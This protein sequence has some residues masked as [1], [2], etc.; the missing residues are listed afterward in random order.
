M[1]DVSNVV[2][3]SVVDNDVLIDVVSKLDTISSQINL[4]NYVVLFVVGMT[5]AGLVVFM[6]YKLISNFIDY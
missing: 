3:N 2:V 5:V 6:F 4:L 1:E